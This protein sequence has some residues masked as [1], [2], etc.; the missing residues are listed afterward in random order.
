[1]AKVFLDTAYVLALVN[2]RDPLHELAVETGAGI[3]GGVVT[4]DAILI[5]V[6][7]ALCRKATRSAAVQVIDML[8]ADPGIESVAVSRE[9]LDVGYSLYRGRTDK[10]WSLTDCI[11]FAVMR[12]RGIRDAL[13][14]DHHFEQ[15]GFVARLR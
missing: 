13:T 9:L 14:S 10:D 2:P 3:D 8:R 7:D 15:A 6:A 5:E 1:M 12:Q 11:S 4:T